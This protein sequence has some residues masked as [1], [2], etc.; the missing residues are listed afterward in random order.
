MSQATPRKYLSLWNLVTF[1]LGLAVVIFLLRQIN[2]QSLAQLILAIKPG[3][4]LAGA[5]LYLIKALFR[6]YRFWR[7]RSQPTATPLAKPAAKPTA[8]PTAKPMAGFTRMLRITLASS[9][10]SQVLPLKLGELTYVYLLKKE[11]SASISQGLSSLLVVRLFDLLAIALLFIVFSLALRTPQSLTVAFGWI[12]AF[13]GLLLGIIT[14]VLVVARFDRKIFGFAGRFGKLQKFALFIRLRDGLSGIFGHLRQFRPSETL[15]WVA[16]AAGE[17]LV[18]FMVFQ[19]ILL[20]ML[21]GIPGMGLAPHFYDTVVSVTFSALASVL[22]INSFGNFGT[23]EAGWTAG[24]MLLGYAQP[25]A[26]YSGFAT[27]LLTLAYM[28]VFGGVAWLSLVIMNAQGR[29]Q[30]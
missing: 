17:W 11:R 26:I 16:L 27:H 3:Y 5:G 15:E 22:P 1:A 7:L 25:A 20:G 21:P 13:I 8:K 10:A 19:V 24:L 23:Q 6:A 28:L 9:L 14:A 18:N 12:L 2:L 4:L 29:V 30:T